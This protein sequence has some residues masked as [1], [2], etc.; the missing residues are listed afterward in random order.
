VVKKLTVSVIMI[1]RNLRM[2]VSSSRS[3]LLPLFRSAEHH[4]LLLPT[5]RGA[6]LMQAGDYTQRLMAV[7]AVTAI[8]DTAEHGR[9]NFRSGRD[10]KPERHVHRDNWDNGNAPL[11]TGGKLRRACLA[12]HRSSSPA[13]GHGLF[14]WKGSCFCRTL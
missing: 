5:R 13:V 2:E 7:L 10:R 9:E 11:S 8:T 1:S 3:I 12:Y 14:Q 6:S 4:G